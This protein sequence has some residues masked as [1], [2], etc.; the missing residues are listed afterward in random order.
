MPLMDTIIEFDSRISPAFE[1]LSIKVISI[2]T[3]HCPL[4]D[5]SIDFE[6]FTRTKINT[7]TKEA[8]THISSIQGT[9]P[10]SISIGHHQESLYIIPQSVH[11]ECNYKIL[12][13]DT[14]D[15]ERILQHS[16]PTLY[17]SEWLLD[18]IKNASILVELK[19]NQNTFIEW[20][21]GIK[22]AVIL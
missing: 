9:I 1:A 14:K 4:Q 5:Y 16:N 7:F 6:F 10:G 15:M 12:H 19:T 20:P 13:I 21:L 8:T 11:I 3:A 2:T 22:S 18:A 17:Y